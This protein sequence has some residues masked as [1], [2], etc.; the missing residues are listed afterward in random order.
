MVS[1]DPISLFGCLTWQRQLKGGDDIR[2][3]WQRNS[4]L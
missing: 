3:K 4:K 2:N 1:S